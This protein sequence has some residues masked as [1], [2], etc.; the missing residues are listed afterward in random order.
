[1]REQGERTAR[2][3]TMLGTLVGAPGQPSRIE[4]IEEDVDELTESKNRIVGAGIGW[5]SFV[6]VALALWEF[7]S[8]KK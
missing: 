7:L 8:H 3:E 5:G 2:I 6:T 4:K 1:M